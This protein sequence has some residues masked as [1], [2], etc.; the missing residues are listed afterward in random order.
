M[1]TQTSTDENGMI[2]LQGDLS[3]LIDTETVAD[4]TVDFVPGPDG[5]LATIEIAPV[6]LPAGLPLLAAS[7][8]GFGLIRARRA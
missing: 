4:T 1:A 7:L 2:T 5:T 8:A 6:P 3:F